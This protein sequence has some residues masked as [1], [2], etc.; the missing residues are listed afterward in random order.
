MR[1]MLCLGIFLL[2]AVAWASASDQRTT[3]PTPPLVIESMTGR[4][5]FVF[6]CAP[7]HGRGGTGDGPVAAAL[8]TTPP[9][10]TTLSRRGGG[11][12]PRGEV[13]AS[14]TGKG[15]AVAAHGSGNMPV[16]GPIFQALDPSNARVK[17]RI[18]NLVEYLESLQAR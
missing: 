13:E 6:Y 18:A 7:C 5:S 1:L 14:V 4:D 11:S 8:K 10:L 2:T 9:D 17:V 16:W 3:Q 15:R 12:F